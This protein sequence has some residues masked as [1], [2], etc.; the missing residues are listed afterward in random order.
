MKQLLLAF[1][2]NMFF[3]FEKKLFSQKE[4]YH[5][6]F[7][8]VFS[9]SSLHNFDSLAL[10]LGWLSTS[11]L[12]SYFCMWLFSFPHTFQWRDYTSNIVH[13]CLLCCKVIGHRCVGLFYYGNLLSVSLINVSAFMLIPYYFDNYS[14]E[15]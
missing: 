1:L 7:S 5:F 11:N 2:N 9:S 13:S 8:S 14:F 12:L 15:V 6:S 4:D 3:F 10:N